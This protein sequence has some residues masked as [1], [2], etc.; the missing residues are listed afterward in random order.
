MARPRR[1]KPE[2]V[3]KAIEDAKG[4]ISAAARRLG[5]QPATVRAYAKCYASVQAAM[6]DARESM[7]DTAESVLYRKILDG[8]TTALIFFLKT[9][10]KSRGYIERQEIRSRPRGKMKVIVEYVHKAPPKQA[11]IR[12]WRGDELQ[13]D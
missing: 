10:G 2:E 13:A 11:E 8:D 4:F 3:T 7:L 12:D 1:Y 9:Q 6:P 5:C